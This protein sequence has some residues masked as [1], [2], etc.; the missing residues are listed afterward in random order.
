MQGYGLED[1]IDD[2]GIPLVFVDPD[3]L[4][5]NDIVAYLPI[6]PGV[7]VD[8]YTDVTWQNDGLDVLEEQLMSFDE[9][10]SFCLKVSGNMTNI[11][12]ISELEAL[13]PIAQVKLRMDIDVIFVPLN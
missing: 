4:S 8:D 10:F 6:E 1:I 7:I 9:S 3:A 5:D 13:D 12:S 11:N 2:L